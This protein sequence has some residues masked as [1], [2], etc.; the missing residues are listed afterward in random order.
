[1]Y[2]GETARNLYT[3]MKEHYSG[4]GEGSSIVKH[5]EEKHEGREGNFVARVTRTNRDCLSR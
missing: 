5:L 1:M 3:R 4:G 2:I